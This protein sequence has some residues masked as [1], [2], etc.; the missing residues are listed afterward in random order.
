[1]NK[2]TVDWKDIADSYYDKSV[3]LAVLLL[4]FAF[5]VSPKIEV[6]PYERIEIQESEVLEIP[7][8][9]EKIQPPAETVKPIV[10]I[11]IDD[12][13]EG[14]DDEEIEI[15]STIEKTTLDPYEDIAENIIGTTSKFAVYEEPP[16]AIKRVRPDY[17]EFA[18]KSGIQ[19]DVVVE[20][21]VFADGTVGAVDIKQSLMSGQGGLDEAAIKA[22]KQW[23]FVPAQ[24]NGK[25]VACWVTFSINFGL[26]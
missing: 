26:N 21:E 20:V 19:G 16:V 7:E 6:K 12:E 24:S 22:V 25:A 9:R 18:K 5:I 3:S 11:V 4:L 17:P 13:L 10:E 14:E 23:E 2:K 8:I 15:I 1:M